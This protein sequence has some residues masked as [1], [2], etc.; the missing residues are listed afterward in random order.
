LRSSSDCD[1]AAFNFDIIQNS[2]F[3][4]RDA[5]RQSRSGASRFA[6]RAGRRLFVPTSAKK[7]SVYDRVVRQRRGITGCQARDGLANPGPPHTIYVHWALQF[8][9]CPCLPAN[10]SD[11]R[12][13]MSAM[14]VTAL[15]SSVRIFFFSFDSV[16]R[17]DRRNA[18]VSRG[19]R[20]F[21]IIDAWCSE[22]AL[23][24]C[25]NTVHNETGD[26]AMPVCEAT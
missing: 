4:N 10:W 2:I 7:V 18:L 17:R 23:D 1:A 5:G 8:P 22:R 24:L 13:S 25:A 19:L 16:V 12:Y 11:H 26:M 20:E 15:G 6:F 21:P 3:R 14:L 9:D